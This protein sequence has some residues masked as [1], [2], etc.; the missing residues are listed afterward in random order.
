MSQFAP[1][2]P[3]HQAL[4]A[5]YALA[6]EKRDERPSKAKSSGSNPLAVVWLAVRVSA[7]Y[8]ISYALPF[9]LR[10]PFMVLMLHYFWQGVRMAAPELVDMA[11][12]FAESLD[13][14]A[15]LLNREYARRGEQ[16]E[17][18]APQRESGEHTE[19]PQCG[20]SALQKAIDAQWARLAAEMEQHAG[21][22][23]WEL[24]R[25]L[26]TEHE[27]LLDENEMRLA[28]AGYIAMAGHCRATTHCLT[29]RR[30]KAHT[31]CD[32]EATCVL[33]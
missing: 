4:Y 21:A 26:L 15:E 11:C 2:H 14:L 30:F 33:F 8:A 18:R 9:L 28:N 13:V 17:S 19:S 6:Q 24:P 23:H 25:G 1:R 3:W 29:L 31:E 27:P 7:L 5:L 10:L 32:C 22:Q 16:L 12:G 20:D